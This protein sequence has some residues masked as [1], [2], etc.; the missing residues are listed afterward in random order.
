LAARFRRIYAAQA[1]SSWQH[2]RSTSHKNPRTN[3]LC[4]ST[5]ADA[6]SENKPS[7]SKDPRRRRA[8]VEAPAEGREEG[9]EVAAQVSATGDAALTPDS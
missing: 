6:R 2:P 4:P 3:D 8:G 7:S 1:S 5:P 9:G